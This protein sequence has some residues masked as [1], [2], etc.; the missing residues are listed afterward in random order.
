MIAFVA[1][2]DES[3]LS[4]AVRSRLVSLGRTAAKGCEGPETVAGG[5]LT[6]EELEDIILEGVIDVLDVVDLEEREQVILAQTK[7]FSLF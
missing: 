1:E 3:E 7:V 5:V 4:L 6:A 2:E